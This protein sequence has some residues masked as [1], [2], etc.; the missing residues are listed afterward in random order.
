MSMRPKNYGGKISMKEILSPSCSVVMETQQQEVMERSVTLRFPL[1]FTLLRC[2]PSHPS[3]DIWL[4]KELAAS[5][6]SFSKFK[7]GKVNCCSRSRSSRTLCCEPRGS[8][9]VWSWLLS[10][11][12]EVELPRTHTHTVA[13]PAYVEMTLPDNWDSL[14]LTR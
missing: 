12:S 2:L 10:R 14:I 13:T 6:S 8:W 7:L 11:L 4:Q 3:L 1:Q 9:S 5:L